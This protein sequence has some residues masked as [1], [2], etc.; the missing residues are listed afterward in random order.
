MRLYQHQRAMLEL[1]TTH[2]QYALFAE[3]GTGKT[4][5]V[6]YHLTNLLMSGAI[7][8][9]LVVCPASVKGSWTRDIEKLPPWRHEYTKY[10]TVVSYDL[11]WRRPEYEKYW[12]AIV[13][14]ES[15]SIAN[16]SSKR[17]KFIHRL[18]KTSEYRYILTGT[19]MHNGHY[20]DYWSQM[21]FLSPGYLGRYEE[22]CAHYTI[23]RQLPGTYVKIIVKYRNVLELLYKIGHMAY[24]IAK[25][26]CL[27]LPEKL[28]PEIIECELQEKKLY[29]EALKGFIEAYDMNLGNPMTIIVKLRAIC[30]G[31]VLDEFDELYQLKCQ[32]MKM[33]DELLDSISG[34]VVIFAEFVYSIK[35]IEELLDKKGLSYYVLDGK[36]RNKAIWRD[37]Q[38]DDTQVMVCQYRSANAGIDLYA[39]STMIFYEPTQS[40]IVVDQAMARIHRNGQTRNCMYYWL[41]TKGTVEEDI[42]KR[43]ADGMDFNV[44]AL[45][46]F[47]EG[48]K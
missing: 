40:S 18:Q 31:F 6:L 41:I 38:S 47:R 17:S 24:Y 20:E 15:H 9:A 44:H 3:A 43:T 1:M 12:G 2:K 26:D 35:K 10:I 22:F 16:R 11:V 37:F 45:E 30:S 21:E 5:P 33:L 23:R 28:P 32:K 46:N 29:K 19:P 48:L 8:N 7:K 36:Q 13:L 14:D 27:D 34:K 42:Y 39:A 25:K 4:L